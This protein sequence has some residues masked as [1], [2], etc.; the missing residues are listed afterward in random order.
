MLAAQRVS[1]PDVIRLAKYKVEVSAHV[2]LGSRF[3][4]GEEGKRVTKD[5]TTRGNTTVVL[6]LACC[7][8]ASG[9][10]ICSVS[11]LL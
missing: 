3:I 9:Q 2:A 5:N 10:F 8:L 6:V 1:Q 4:R 7:F 11:L